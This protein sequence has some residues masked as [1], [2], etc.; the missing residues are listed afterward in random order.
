MKYRL[1]CGIEVHVQLNTKTKLFCSCVNE[2]TPDD[3]NKNICEFCTG[4]PGSLPLL[5]AECVRKAIKLG[6]SLGST[7]PEKTRW[8]RKNYFYPDL[9]T[10]Y[11]IS[12]FDNPVVEGGNIDFYIENKDTG[13][14]SKS[15]VEITRAHL[16][17]DA[18]KLIHAG[19]KTMVD[20][21][22]CAAPLIEIVTEPCI[23][24]VSQAMAFV[25][26]LQLLVR[27]LGISDADMDKGQMRFDCNISLQNA[28]QQKND[29]LPPY[30]VEVKNI[31]SI[32]SMGRAMEFEIIRQEKILNDGNIPKQ[33]T[34]G[35]K[36]DEGVSVSQRNKEDAMDYRYFPEP[37][38]QILEISRDE[39]PS[40][41]DLVELPSVQRER[42]LKIGIPHQTTNTF[43]TQSSAGKVLDS[44]ID[45]AD[46]G[47]EYSDNVVITA[48]NIIAVNL[49]AISIKDEKSI[50]NLMSPSNIID[51]AKLFD[52]K[53]ISNS[54]LKKAID[55]LIT[56]P[57]LE[58][59]EIVATKGLMQVNDDTVLGAFVDLAIQNN[60][61]PVEEYKSGKVQVIGFLIGQCMKESKGKGNP[62]KF[63]EILKKKM[64]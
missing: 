64:M 19:G 5:N 51:L 44:V 16:E 35:W 4:Q 62:Q 37:D 22:R 12:Q 14:F 48:A 46:A 28:E 61:A 26:E 60:P 56:N 63:G 21:N 23:H 53:K 31:N 50:E 49:I 9:P 45:I 41:E 47:D 43:V 54:G 11:Q 58:A 15:N 20:F 27:R 6:V 18:A 10:G 24:E 1:V 29:E 8:D 39:I 34:R 59:R 55:F 7:I 17:A 36:D 42:Y 32:R 3:P 40:I 13:E 25:N 52:S 38:L 30:R 33:E 2:Y 57:D